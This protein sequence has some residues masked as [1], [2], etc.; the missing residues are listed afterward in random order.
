VLGYVVDGGCR[1]TEFILKI[2][3]PV[4]FRFHTPSDIVGRWIPDRFAEPITI[5]DV[6]IR[7]GDYLLGDR[8][9]V[10]VVPQAVAADAVTKTEEV[11]QTENKV[12]AAILGGMDP[13]EAYLKY[14]KF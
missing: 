11:V 6:T 1:D 14:G 7:D 2:G 10:V 9:G 3:F 5:G 13:V 12:R 8:D 4:F